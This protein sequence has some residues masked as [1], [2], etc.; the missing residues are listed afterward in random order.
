MVTARRTAW[1]GMAWALCWPLMQKR[2]P[3]RCTSGVP[4]VESAT[5]RYEFEWRWETF[6]VT[7]SQRRGEAGGSLTR[8]TTGRVASSPSTTTGRTG[9]A[10][11]CGPG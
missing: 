11:W 2:Q 8:E 6:A 9:T 3:V 4:A 5:R 1:S 7:S 10:G